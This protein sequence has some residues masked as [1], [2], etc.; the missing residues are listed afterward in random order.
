M[1]KQIL[2]DIKNIMQGILI[3]DIVGILLL[4]LLKKLTLATVG[5]L[6]LGSLISIVALL[7]IAKNMVGLVEKEKVGAAVTAT[8]GYAVRL[9]M[10]AAVLVFAAKTRYVNVFTVFFGLISVS[11]VIKVEQLVLKYKN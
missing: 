2:K 8:A 3:Y 10:Y 9:L 5:G 11:M 6:L 7:M 4:L 1:D